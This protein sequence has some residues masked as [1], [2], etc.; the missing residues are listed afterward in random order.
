MPIPNQLLLHPNGTMFEFERTPSADYR[1]TRS[2]ADST[3]KTVHFL[4]LE[5]ATELI[6]GL[7]RVNSKKLTQV[8]I[9]TFIASD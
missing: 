1:V 7:M 8:G 5:S 4:T 2:E 9:N 6:F 3:I